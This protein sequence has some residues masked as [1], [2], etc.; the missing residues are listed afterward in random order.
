M[1]RVADALQRSF[2]PRAADQALE[3]VEHPWEIAAAGDVCDEPALRR[4]DAVRPVAASIPHLA[5]VSTDD[6]PGR[7]SD[8]F[9]AWTRSSRPID[10]DPSLRPHIAAL[11]GR[12]FAPASGEPA[13]SV[14]FSG[15]GVDTALITA[16]TAD[17][18]ATQTS[19]SVCVVDARFSAP[20]LH[21]QF[22]IESGMGLT[23][24]IEA[25]VPL[26]DLA[27]E[28]RPDLWLL[29]N[30]SSAHR[31]SFT[32]DGVRLRLAQFIA[33]FDYVLIDIDPVGAVSDAA[34]LTPLLDGV[35]LVLAADTTRRESA[36]RAAQLLQGGGAAVLGAVLMNR[37]YPIPD[38][39][40]RRL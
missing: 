15:V 33:R 24:A 17:M 11:V 23:D 37:R 1:S 21:R 22:G 8:A 20:A 39:L 7:L 18:L 25:G 40:Y 16:A 2:G 9:D 30:G 31:P 38:A 29:R 34:G 12:V 14:A 6:A 3:D 27:C 19:S 10:I 35:I 4:P 28:L 32:S 13:R 36:R 26:A 5:A